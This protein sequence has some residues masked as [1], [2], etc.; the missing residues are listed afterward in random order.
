M[1]AGNP[2][3]LQPHA[4]SGGDSLL[5][6]T[7]ARPM[8]R[9]MSQEASSGIVLII[10]TAAALIWA[11]LS[12]D[13]YDAFWHFKLN[14]EV[15][16]REIFSET[17]EH[18]VSDGLMVIFFFV[19]GMEI[20]SELVTGDLREPRVAALPAIAAI[21][22]MLVP[23]ILFYLVNVGQPG[24]GGWGIPVATDIAFALGVLALLGHRIPKKLKLFLLTL[25][26]VDDIGAILVIAVFYTTSISFGWLGLALGLLGLIVV[27]KRLK[28]WFIPLY[29]GLGV[30]VWYAFLESGVHATIAGVILGLLTPATALIGTNPLERVREILAG[31]EH[32]ERIDAL[33]VKEA[34]WTAK[35]SVPVTTRLTHLVSPWASFIIIP[36]FA[37]ANAGIVL[38]GDA[39]GSALSSRV[40]LGI[41]LGLVIGKP[42]GIT[43]ATWIAVKFKIASLPEGV[44]F[45]HVLG[46]G[47]VAGIGFTLSLFIASLAFENLDESIRES[48]LSE[49]I[50]GILV[51]SAIATIAGC[52]ILVTV[53]K[54]TDK[55][56]EEPAPEKAVA[57]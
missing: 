55:E 5:A 32:K 36:L 57:V 27:L 14:I 53:S 42:L 13:S 20:K 24:E 29:A 6:K 16:G 25:A 56:T 33:Q 26:I 46:G 22:G 31:E 8:V 30:V 37:I 28:V 11:N 54:K 50:I 41:V 52:L 18:V 21:G 45:G 23:G 19:V 44:N 12:F 34:N 15:A 4:W 2:I 1:S 51:A 43:L 48:I 10:A 49:S 7:V 39:I 3:K 35:E 9:F 38:S 47:A 17:L 40:A